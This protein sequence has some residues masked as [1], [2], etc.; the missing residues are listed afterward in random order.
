ME[1]GFV[2]PRFRRHF[3]DLLERE[4]PPQDLLP[5][6][7]ISR[8]GVKPE[9]RLLSEVLQETLTCLKK[10]P[11]SGS[12]YG[13]EAM[14]SQADQQSASQSMSMSLT[15]AEDDSLFRDGFGVAD[16]SL[17][18]S[19]DTVAVPKDDLAH[20]QEADGEE[21]EKTVARVLEEEPW[22]WANTVVEKCEE[23]VKNAAGKEGRDAGR[24]D[25][26]VKEWAGM[27]D[28]RVVGDGGT[29][30]ALL[31]A[32]SNGNEQSRSSDILLLPLKKGK[33]K[34]RCDADR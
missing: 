16:L 10:P 9:K 2:K 32:N 28:V 33:K 13:S 7:F 21:G 34:K 11:G 23:L 20:Q 30:M 8:L 27:K 24:P 25:R 14:P 4:R 18:S 15:A 12:G 29:W 22:V 31:W 17:S 26:G 19:A 6:E 5:E 1:N 3:P